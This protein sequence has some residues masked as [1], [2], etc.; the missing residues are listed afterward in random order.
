MKNILLLATAILLSWSTSAQDKLYLVFELMTVDNEQETAYLETEDFWEKIHQNRVNEGDILGWELWKLLPGGEMQN[1]Q[2]M[3]VT[4][5]SDPV[6]MMTGPQDYQALFKASYPDNSDEELDQKMKSTTSSRDLAFRIYLLELDRTEDQFEIPVGTVAVINMMKVD[7][8]SFANYEK[9]ESEV[10][11]PWHQD[12]VNEG[13][14]ASWSLF[15]FLSPYGSATYASHI[16]V[17]LY[18][19][20]SQYFR[21]LEEDVTGISYAQMQQMTEGLASRDHKYQYIGTLL[22][23]VTR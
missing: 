8:N 15:R 13:K 21:A 20:F 22:K 17:D 6:K 19:D 12:A 2:Y 7:L 4:L 16:T 5:Y 3:T 14:R 11:K 9:I 23:K 1:F 10:Y 18:N